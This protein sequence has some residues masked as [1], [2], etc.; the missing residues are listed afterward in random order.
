MSEERVRDLLSSLA[1]EEV[2]LPDAD[3]VYWR[4]R[5]IRLLEEEEKR[6]TDAVRPLRVLHLLLGF[7]SIAAATVLPLA[8][9]L[10]FFAAPLSMVAM[11]LG[12]WFFLEASSCVQ[13]PGISLHQR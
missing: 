11:A 5:A 12:G 9:T 10:G 3:T 1:S 13:R 4:A 8:P 6:R 7:G 2:E